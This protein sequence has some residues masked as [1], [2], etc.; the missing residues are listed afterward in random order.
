MMSMVEDL[1]DLT[2][3]HQASTGRGQDNVFDH[4]REGR[5]ELVLRD[6]ATRRGTSD[7]P[8]NERDVLRTGRTV[9]HEAAA[10]GRTDLV[11][12]LVN[13]DIEVDAAG[14]AVWVGPP[15]DP[16]A[17]TYLGWDTALHLAAS[18]SHRGA[19]LA[20]L[21]AGADPNA[22]N[23]YGATPLHCCRPGRRGTTVARVLVG[24]GA[25]PTLLD[26]ADRTP[27]GAIAATS[28]EGGKG[29]SDDDDNDGDDEL[30]QY[31]QSEEDRKIGNNIRYEISSHRASRAEAEKRE[32][33]RREREEKQRSKAVGAKA[34][35]EYLRWRTCSTQ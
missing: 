6:I 3:P 32:A 23:R 24:H 13:V 20:L 12:R 35:E 16:G 28:S 7:A 1:I 2:T 17:R 15:A 34:M 19:A 33:A 31:L 26:V 8:V 18:N 30:V 10:N 4:A 14:G 27:A 5:T 25:D 29:G 11:R 22:R 21:Q 9:L